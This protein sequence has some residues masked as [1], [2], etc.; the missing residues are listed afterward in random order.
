MM[1]RQIRITMI[2]HGKTAGNRLGRYIGVTDERLCEEGVGQWLELLASRRAKLP[3]GDD[4]ACLWVVSPLI[5]CLETLYGIL[6]DLPAVRLQCGEL[7]DQRYAGV[8][9]ERL[10]NLT[11]GDR[12]IVADG[13]RECDFGLFE[14]QNYRELSDLPAYQ[15][16]VDSNGTLP[17]PGGEDPMGFRRRSCQAFETV[18]RSCPAEVEHVVLVVHGGT[19]MSL[20]E[21]MAEETMPDGTKKSFYDWH[22]GNGGGY[23]CQ[24]ALTEDGVSLTEV[25]VF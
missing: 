25:E 15:A 24:A 13:L 16:W 21:T 7:N 1:K 18:L 4:T 14:N 10:V 8:L 2:R 3:E 22:V 17:F 23:T 11:G 5:R 6:A 9:R 20:M 12:L 19:I